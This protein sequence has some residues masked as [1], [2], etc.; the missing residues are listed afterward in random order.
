VIL[1]AHYA[2]FETNRSMGYEQGGQ[3]VGHYKSLPADSLGVLAFRLARSVMGKYTL[4]S[5]L[6]YLVSTSRQQATSRRYATRPPLALDRGT[7]SAICLVFASRER[8]LL[9]MPGFREF[10]LI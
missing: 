5:W 9:E 4:S 1:K 8:A 2:D 7:Q 3:P 6:D 10:V